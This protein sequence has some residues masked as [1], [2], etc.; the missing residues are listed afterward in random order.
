MVARS[1][2]HPGILVVLQ[3]GLKQSRFDELE[4]Q[5]HE[6]WSKCLFPWTGSAESHGVDRTQLSYSAGKNWIKARLSVSNFEHLLD[7]QYFINEHEDGTRLV[8]AAAWSP[9][10]QL[11]KHF[12]MVQPT[13]SF[14]RPKPDRMSLNIVQPD[15]EIQAEP[16]PHRRSAISHQRD[17]GKSWIEW[18]GRS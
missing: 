4:K 13:N 18:R 14:F 6:G 7:T 9:P 1:S 15:L 11:H 10:S 16:S 2:C 5:L 3:I 8:R 17:S 12:E